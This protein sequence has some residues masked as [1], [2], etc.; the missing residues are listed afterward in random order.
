MKAGPEERHLYDLHY[1]G[2][3]MQVTDMKDI[4]TAL[5]ETGEPIP[6]FVQPSTHQAALQ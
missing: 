4:Q 6:F 2:N 3:T 5:Y 1:G